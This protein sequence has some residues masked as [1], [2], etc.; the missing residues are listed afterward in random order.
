M[1]RDKGTAS[2]RGTA[3]SSTP[4]TPRTQDDRTPVLYTLFVI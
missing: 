1:H 2:V 3:D 4:W